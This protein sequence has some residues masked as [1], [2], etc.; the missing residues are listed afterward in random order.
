LQK[1]CRAAGQRL[2]V[3]GKIGHVTIK[4]VNRVPEPEFMAALQA[5]AVSK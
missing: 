2:Y 5:Q 4:A 1:A 3:D